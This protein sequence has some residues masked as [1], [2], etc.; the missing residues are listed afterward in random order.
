MNLETCAKKSDLILRATKELRSVGMIFMII[1]DDG[2][3][4]KELSPSEAREKVAH[5]FRDASRTAKKVEEI[6]TANK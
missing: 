5:R 1:T 6:P 2:V 3:M 4:L